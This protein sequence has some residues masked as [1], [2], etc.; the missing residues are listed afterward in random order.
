MQQ[1][2]LSDPSP[3]SPPPSAEYSAVQGGHLGQ[4]QA[5]RARPPIPSIV[6]HTFYACLH[7]TSRIGGQKRRKVHQCSSPPHVQGLLWYKI[8][9]ASVDWRPNG[10]IHNDDS[11]G[12]PN[13]IYE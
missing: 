9:I 6:K 11:Q 13:K 3:T 10:P 2:Y 12:P 5:T 1:L 4:F 8:N 7:A